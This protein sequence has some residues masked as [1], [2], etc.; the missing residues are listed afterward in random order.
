M[1]ESLIKKDVE[2][3]LLKFLEVANSQTYANKSAPKTKS[4]K[5]HSQ[6][7][8]FERGDFKYHDT[9]F[10]S[11]NF[12]GSE[13]VYFKEK[14]IWGLNYYGHILKSDIDENEL[15]DFLREAL[16]KEANNILPLRG[17]SNYKKN[18][19]SYMFTVEGDMNNFK[20]EEIIMIDDEIVYRCYIHGGYI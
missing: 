1:E 7:Y 12:I 4:S 16:L 19:K 8:Y 10:G 15:Y 11:R 6:D 14:V 18:D 3:E 17:P 2:R 13:V 9:Y 5:L 20:G